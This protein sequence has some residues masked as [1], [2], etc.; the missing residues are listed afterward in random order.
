MLLGER[1]V[2]TCGRLICCDSELKTFV[3]QQPYAHH[4]PDRTSASKT[5][6][7]DAGLEGTVVARHIQAQVAASLGC[8]Q[9]VHSYQVHQ[10]QVLIQLPSSALVEQTMVLLN[11]TT[12]NGHSVKASQ[13]G[14]FCCHCAKVLPVTNFSQRQLNPQPELEHRKIT[15][16]PVLVDKQTYNVDATRC[17]FNK[18]KITWIT[19]VQHTTRCKS[20]VLQATALLEIAAKRGRMPV[21]PDTKSQDAND[22]IYSVVKSCL[23][24]NGGF[25]P[26]SRI[27]EGVRTVRAAVKRAG[28]LLTWLET[29]P[30]ALRGFQVDGGRGDNNL[31]VRLLPDIEY[32]SP[33]EEQRRATE[34]EQRCLRQHGG[35]LIEHKEKPIQEQAA[36]P[37]KF[38]D[39]EIQ[40]DVLIILTQIGR[41]SALITSVEG[42][43]RGPVADAVHRAGGLLSWLETSEV[44]ISSFQVGGDLCDRKSNNLVVRLRAAVVPAKRAHSGKIPACVGGHACVA[45]TFNSGSYRNGWTCTECRKK[46]S[47]ERWFCE[48][49]SEDYCYSCWP[50]AGA[51]GGPA[52]QKSNLDLGAN[53]ASP[54]LSPNHTHSNQDDDDSAMTAVVQSMLEGHGG[55]CSAQLLI[56]GVLQCAIGARTELGGARAAMERAGG[57]VSWLETTV[58]GVR[59]FQIQRVG[60][61]VTVHL[62]TSATDDDVCELISTLMHPGKSFVSSTTIGQNLGRGPMRTVVKAAG[63][64]LKWVKSCEQVCTRFKVEEAGQNG[65]FYLHYRNLDV[66]I[67]PKPHIK[68]PPANDFSNNKLQSMELAATGGAA[69][70]K[71]VKDTAVEQKQGGVLTQPFFFCDLA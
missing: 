29:S 54:A 56:A 35:R 32:I 50:A 39:E 17:N 15:S 24:S 22:D 59:S 42:R 43:I 23:V 9:D 53:S 37:G 44:A 18:R 58:H 20:C 19:N 40:A 30:Q 65:V 8:E 5:V 66:P 14:A 64:L 7:V 55:S 28:G 46:R 69:T 4:C 45:S 31:S 41:S 67:R 12:V 71:L 25:A 16:S 34:Q 70:G 60:H 57:L 11:Q 38:G 13:P 33:R 26:I 6:L 36:D 47:G 1:T 63:G 68:E 21:T 10:H 2:L 51:L 61:N 48:T 27:G 52:E 62:R 49:C 3:T